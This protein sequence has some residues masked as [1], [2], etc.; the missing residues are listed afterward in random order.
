MLYRDKPNFA[1]TVNA[2]SERLGISP[3]AV[4][5]D[6]WVSEVLRDLNRVHAGDF[7]LKGGTS[8]SK[9][10]GV[11]NRFSEDIDLL[12]IP[13]ER[14]R[15]ATDTLI[16]SM[17]DDAAEAVGGEAKSVGGAEQGRHRAYEVS[18][19]TPRPQTA[20]IQTRVLLEMGIRGG[21]WP[22]RRVA[23]GS[24]LGDALAAAGV[25]IPAFDDLRPFK[26]VCLHPARTLLEKLFA[27]HSVALAIEADPEF[28]LRGHQGRHGYDVYQLLRDDDVLAVVSD[29]AQLHPILDDIEEYNRRF[30]GGVERPPDG[31]SQS[32]A[33]EGRATRASELLGSEYAATMPDLYFGDAPLPTWRQI[34]QR[35][36]DVGL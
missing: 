15:G 28:A 31:F 8:L 4:E 32:P 16:K 24:L 11:T 20:T 35:V 10:Y 7:I 22:A 18:Y 6:Y 12:I 9:G 25:D 13:G 1:A 23:I 2:A 27:L 21:D 33:F 30:F 26:M 36:G 5:K 29:P 34:G 17:A 3:T 14:G 19:P